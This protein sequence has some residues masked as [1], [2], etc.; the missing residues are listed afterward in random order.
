MCVVQVVIVENEAQ[1]KKIV[2]LP[3]DKLNL[4][5]VVQYSGT[6]HKPDPFPNVATKFL[7]VQHT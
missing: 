5:A 1:L 3:L 6:M 7:Q 4:L 2:Q